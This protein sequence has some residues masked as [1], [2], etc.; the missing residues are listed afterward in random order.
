MIVIADIDSDRFR[1][2]QRVN[3]LD[4]GGHYG[5]IGIGKTNSLAPRPG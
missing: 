1:L 5:V 3:H 2:A 4:E